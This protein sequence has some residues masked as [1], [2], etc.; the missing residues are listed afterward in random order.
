MRALALIA[1]AL[2]ATM[3]TTAAADTLMVGPGQA[4]AMPCD[5][6]GSANA[7]DTIEVD[8]AGSYDGDTCAWSTDNLTIRGINGR[9]KIDL[10]GVTPVQQKGIFTINAP[11][12]TIESFE[13]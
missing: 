6:I 5:A 2:T 3:T 13:F 11:N 8:A 7:G 1:V 10:T 9:A 12:A 4:Y